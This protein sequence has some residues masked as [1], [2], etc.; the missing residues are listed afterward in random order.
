MDCDKVLNS[1]FAK[2]IQLP[3]YAVPVPTVAVGMA[4][5]LFLGV[6]LLLVGRLPGRL[7][8]AWAIPS[9]IGLC[10]LLA[11][12]GMVYV[13]ARVLHAWCGLCLL[14]QAVDLVLVLGIWILWLAGGRTAPAAEPSLASSPADSAGSQLWKIPAMAL[15]AGLAVGLAQLRSAQTSEAVGMVSLAQVEYDYITNDDQYRKF[16]FDK[17]RKV[18]IP[19]DADDPTSG[20][21]DARHTLVI[22]ADFQCSHCAEFATLVPK[23]QNKLPEP[24]RVVFKYFPL[25]SKCNPSRPPLDLDL[26]EPGCTAAAAA[27]AAREMGGNDAFWKAH[28]VLLK[29]HD[30]IPSVKYDILA[31]YLGLDPATFDRLRNDPKAMDRVRKVAAEGARAGVRTTPA[32]FLDGRRIEAPWKNTYDS[33]QRKRVVDVNQTIAYWK[34]LLAWSDRAAA[35]QQATASQPAGTTQPVRA[36]SSQPM[37]VAPGTLDTRPSSMD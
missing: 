4:Y 10:G 30:R 23:I 31:K 6:W 24:M 35:S 1:P 25:S 14:V 15:L 29:G 7:H 11:S 26:F 20:P 34:N 27:E 2:A 16:V 17:A 28:E 21:A 32:V 5:F 9:L 12:G 36:E 37:I 13:M 19:I 22:F 3:P 18:E 8:H 33:Q